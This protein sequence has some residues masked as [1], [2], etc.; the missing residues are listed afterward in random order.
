MVS[1]SLNKYERTSPVRVVRMRETLREAL[2]DA[3]GAPPEF[4]IISKVLTPGE[5]LD[6]SED[7]R[8]IF[9]ESHA[10]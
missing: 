5:G 9:R 10:K 3:G 1:Y 6:V 4:M 8:N 2:G 7:F